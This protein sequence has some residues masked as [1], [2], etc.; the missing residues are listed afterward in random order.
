M[1]VEDEV[2]VAKDISSRLTQIGYDVIGTAGRGREAIDLAIE[3]RPD[4]ILM[5]IHLRDEIDGIE[6]AQAIQKSFDVPIIFCTAYSNDETLQRAKV[7]APYGYTLKPFDNRELEINIE[8]P[9][10][11]HHAEKTLRETEGRL[12]TT[13]GN[14]SDGVIAT[15]T[16]GKV[17]LV[18]SVAESLIEVNARD[19]HE[20]SIVQLL[21]LRNFDSQGHGLDLAS[22]VLDK[23]ENLRSVRQH[24]VRRN[25][26]E[27][28]V[29]IS[30]NQITGEGVHRDTMGMVVSIRDI[31][32]L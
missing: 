6:A 16:D 31:S 13:L 22:A 32:H 4:L 8:I 14:I 27:V 24:L 21:E 30:A 19:A 1:V 23:G 7:T 10:Y 5:D 20:M 26:S 17:F 29:E 25:G 2:L 12:N 3:L 18:N 28:P 15:D 11:K 9:L